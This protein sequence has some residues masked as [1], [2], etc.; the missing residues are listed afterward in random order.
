MELRLKR[1]LLTESDMNGNELYTHEEDESMGVNPIWC[2]VEAIQTPHEVFTEVLP[3]VTKEFKYARLPI[4][5][6][7]PTKIRVREMKLRQKIRS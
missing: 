1:D 3:Q 2:N 7:R 5:P 6:E 4:T